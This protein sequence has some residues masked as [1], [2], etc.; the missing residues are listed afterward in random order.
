ME[1]ARTGADG[2]TVADSAV[3]GSGEGEGERGGRERGHRM[4]QP[5]ADEQWYDAVT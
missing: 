1:N 4:R 2:W 3:A 5:R